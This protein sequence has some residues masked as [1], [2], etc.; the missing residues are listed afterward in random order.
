MAVSF[1]LPDELEQ[2]LR[3]QSH[4]LEGEAKAA[5]VLELFRCGK[6]THYELSQI[7]AI[8]R[9]ETD[10]LLKKHNVYEGSI[11]FDDLEADRQTLERVLGPAH[12]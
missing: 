9:P 10:A 2:K 1:Q 7:L 12:R 11:T 8:D 6:L 5:Y 3:S 4:D